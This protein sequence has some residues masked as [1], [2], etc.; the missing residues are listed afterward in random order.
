MGG[1][2]TLPLEIY[3]MTTNIRSQALYALGTVTTFF[4]FIMV[5]LFLFISSYLQR[6]R[7]VGRTDQTRDPN[8]PVV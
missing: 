5:G 4:T 3:V 7:S 6:R 1:K 8:A 2:N